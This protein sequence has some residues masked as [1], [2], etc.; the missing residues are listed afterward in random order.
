ML[1]FLLIF[2]LI[3]CQNKKIHPSKGDVIE[4][5][6]GL[7]IIKS[8]NNYNARAAI[9]SSVKEFYVTEGQEVT[10]GQKL[11]LTDQGSVYAAPFSGKVTS[12]PV[13]VGEN[14]FPQTVI[15]SLIDLN[16]LYL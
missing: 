4:A 13:P 3:S 7:G 6:Y 15:L 14:L 16:H 2:L 1:K 5:V 10:K 9:L 11:F 8:E 12:I